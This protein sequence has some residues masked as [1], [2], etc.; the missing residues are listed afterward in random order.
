[1]GAIERFSNEASLAVYVGM[2]PLDCSSGKYVSAKASRHVNIRAKAAI[3]AALSKH[4]LLMPDAKQYYEKKRAEGKKHNQAVRAFG[5]HM[6][7]VIWSMLKQG[8]NYQC[9]NFN[10]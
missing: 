3:M 2:A 4:I 10:P 8:R 1:M 5:R 7:R 6:V 9:K